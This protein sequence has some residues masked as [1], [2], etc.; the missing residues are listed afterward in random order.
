MFSDLNQAN[1][2]EC[3]GRFRPLLNEDFGGFSSGSLSRPLTKHP[4]NK[5]KLPS[6]SKSIL[7]SYYGTLN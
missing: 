5:I 4:K 2:Y 1:Y 6:S 7:T 3:F